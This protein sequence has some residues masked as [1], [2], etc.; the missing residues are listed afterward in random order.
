MSPAAETTP[1][2]ADPCVPVGPPLLELRAAVRVH[3]DGAR[4]V[5]ALDGVNLEVAVGEFV[6]IM[7]ASGSGK[8][9]LLH[10]AGGLAEPTSGQVLIDGTPLEALRPAARAALRRDTIGYV[11]QDLNLLPALTATENVAFPRELAGIPARR[12]RQEALTALERVDIAELADR[13]PN[14][15][16][17]GQAQRVAIARALVGERRLLLADEPTGALDSATARDVVNTLRHAA[18]DGLAVVM[19]THEARLAAWAD[20][21]V[22]LQD[23]R[24]VG[25][26]GGEMLPWGA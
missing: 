20:R 14:E 3:G 11:F 7:G 13:R 23:G 12:A 19:V 5:R 21:I 10:L 25:T 26:T 2:P 9:T 4:Q 15:L 17:G 6:A 24:V 22:Q 8:S 16:S 1:R 18:D